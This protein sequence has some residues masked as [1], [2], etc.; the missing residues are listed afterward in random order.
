MK[1]ASLPGRGRDG[2][3][4]VVSDDLTRCTPAAAVADTLQTA[5][6]RWDRA[7]TVLER[8]ALQLAEDDAPDATP[9]PTDRVLAPLPRAYQFLDGSAY[10]THEELVRSV[11]GSDLPPGFH[12]AP[13][14]YQ[15]VSDAFLAPTAPLLLGDESVGLDFE[16]EIA[17]IVDDVPR[18]VDRAAALDHI[19]LVAVL[20]DL[21]LRHVMVDE[22]A[23]GFGFVLSKPHSSLS[24]LAVSPDSLGSAWRDGRLHGR[25]VTRLDGH[26]VGNPD[27]GVDMRFDF[28][29][30]IVH[31]ARTRPLHAGTLVGG[32]V[33]Q[34]RDPAT[35][36]SSLEQRAKARH[37]D[38]IR[39]AGA[40]LKVGDRVEI[41][42]FDHDGRSLFGPIDHRVVAGTG[43]AAADASDTS[44]A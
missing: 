12:Q 31:A 35:G 19:K 40:Y 24:P 38:E 22:L 7:S 23:R 5:L 33:V 29:D 3:L 44:A 8:L 39:A 16:S 30:L 10:L 11:R 21:S 20:N 1:L 2:R 13:L 15:G 28:A 42:M 27:P 4:V 26:V 14:M 43:D 18:G 25:L 9:F 17:V 6:E 32:G 37:G 41:E 36:F 34:N